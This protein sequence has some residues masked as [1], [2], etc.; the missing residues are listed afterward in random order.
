MQKSLLQNLVY[1]LSV[2]LGVKIM[3]NR[4]WS[5]RNHGEFLKIVLARTYKFPVS[6]KRTISMTPRWEDST[7]ICT[8][9]IW[10]IWMEKTLKQ[11]VHLKGIIGDHPLAEDEWWEDGVQQMLRSKF[12]INHTRNGLKW[13]SNIAVRCCQYFMY[14]LLYVRE[15]ECLSYLI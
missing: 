6:K 7:N 2:L 13:L 15:D 3:K 4:C 14:V 8:L 10:R 11:L 12:V 5:Q 9:I 1:L